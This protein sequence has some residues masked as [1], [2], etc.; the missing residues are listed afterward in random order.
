[1]ARRGDEA[2]GVRRL[3]NL[4]RELIQPPDERDDVEAGDEATTV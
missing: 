1:M 4:R 3:Q 2:Y